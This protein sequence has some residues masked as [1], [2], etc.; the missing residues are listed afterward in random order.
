MDSTDMSKKTGE[1]SNLSRVL[2]LL[3]LSGLQPGLSSAEENAELHA[4][5]LSVTISAPDYV[6]VGVPS[7]VECNYDCFSCTFSMSLDGQ[8][9]QGQGNVLAFTLKTWTRVLTVTCTVSDDNTSVSGRASKQLQV[10]AGPANIFISGPDFINS[11]KSFKYSCHADC[12]PF[13]NYAWK[14]LNAPW[15]GGQGNAISITPHEIQSPEEVLICKATN[16]VSKM[17]VAAT[18]KITVIIPN[19]SARPEEALVVLLLAFITSAAFIM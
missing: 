2:L 12:Q 8:V 4:D 7:S 18:K 19:L 3:F 13:C 10:L 14:T 17:F 1:H 11:T 6:T 9:A 16:S 15:I 5:S